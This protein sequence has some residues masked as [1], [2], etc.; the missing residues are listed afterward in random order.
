MNVVWSDQCVLCKH[1]QAN[2]GLV[3]PK[4]RQR[5]LCNILEDAKD[6]AIADVL[7]QL[8]LGLAKVGKCPVRADRFELLDT[9]GYLSDDEEGRLIRQGLFRHTIEEASHD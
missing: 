5:F 2:Q 9:D 6:A 4:E 3:I 8:L 7:K 1:G